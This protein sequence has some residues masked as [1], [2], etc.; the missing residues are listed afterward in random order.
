MYLPQVEMKKTGGREGS[1][2]L[3]LFL[4]FPPV[5]NVWVWPFR[6]GSGWGTVSCECRACSQTLVGTVSEG[7]MDWF[8]SLSS[9]RS[10]CRT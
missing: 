2:C 4:W 9:S 8:L 5:L 10:D 6:S 1:V 7:S 3:F